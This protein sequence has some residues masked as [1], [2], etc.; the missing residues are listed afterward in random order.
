LRRE[1]SER[2]DVQALV[3]ELIRAYEKQEEQRQ[4]WQALISQREAIEQKLASG[5]TPQELEEQARSLRHIREQSAQ[6]MQETNQD[7]ANAQAQ[8]RACLNEIGATRITIIDPAL[9]YRIEFANGA[10]SFERIAEGGGSGESGGKAGGAS[11][12]PQPAS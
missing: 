11:E 10:F 8:V 2:T 12:I 3:S 6:L 7:W 4:A 5:V 1:R 9:K